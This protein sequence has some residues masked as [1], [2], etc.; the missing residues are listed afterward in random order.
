MS[1]LRGGAYKKEASDVKNTWGVSF[2]IYFSKKG[3]SWQKQ[4]LIYCI[5][6]RKRN[7]FYLLRVAKQITKVC[8]T[9]YEQRSRL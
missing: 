8:F 1:V 7:V 5:E 4:D 2:F 6:S 9:C 3:N